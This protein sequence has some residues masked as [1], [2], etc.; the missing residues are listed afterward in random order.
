MD[1]MDVAKVVVPLG[2]AILAGSKTV[3]TK[4]NQGKRLAFLTS[5]A[6]LVYFR[7]EWEKTQPSVLGWEQGDLK[8]PQNARLRAQMLI[9]ELCSV[10]GQPAPDLKET[11]YL[12][13]FFV[14]LAK[15]SKYA[16]PLL[17]S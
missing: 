4:V 5:A 16:G 7:I 2:V 10:S 6:N 15:A 8:V 12:D 13:K 14:N 1:W 11:Q 17:K 3:M 9:G